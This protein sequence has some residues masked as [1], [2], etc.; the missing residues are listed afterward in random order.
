MSRID[1]TRPFI[2]LSIAVLTV[3]D[4]RSL[5]DDRAGDTLVQR[6]EAA[7]HRLAARA[8][9]P[10]EIDEIR[11]TVKGWIADPGIDAVITTGG[12]GFTGRDVTPEAIEPLFEKRMDGFSAVFHRISYDKIGTS[13]L[14]SRATAGVAG[15]TY[16]FVLP[17]S[18]G[19][20]KDAWDGILAAQLDYRQRPCNFVEIMPRLDEHL[21]RGTGS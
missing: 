5:A 17:G 10:D 16:I 2:P 11:A 14:Q 4:T 19:A 13:T 12:T 3:S 7:G 15:A 20:C 6:L 18:P 1:E 21:R 9:V 8:I